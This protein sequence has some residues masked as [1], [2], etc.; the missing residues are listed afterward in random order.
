MQPNLFNT[1]E[2]AAKLGISKRSLQE[3]A[4]NRRIGYIKIGR[5]IRFSQDDI[6]RF[7]E[8][9]RVKPAGWKGAASCK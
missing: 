5:N 3:H 8:S 6:D 4:A 2:T 9:N 7:I 1:P